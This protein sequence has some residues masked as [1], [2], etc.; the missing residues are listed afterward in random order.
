M[1]YFLLISLSLLSLFA[2]ET[3]QKGKIDMHGGSQDNYFNNYNNRGSYKDGG[4]KN[5]SMNMSK[6]LDKN[7]SKNSRQ[8]QKR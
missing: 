6:F 1:K 5:S 2:Q 3:Y 7:T 4:F 8:S